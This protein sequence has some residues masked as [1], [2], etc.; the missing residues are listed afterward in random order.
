MFTDFSFSS[1]LTLIIIFGA[2][3]LLHIFFLNQHRAMSLLFAIYAS[4]LV[5]LF[6]P[7]NNW[8]TDMSLEKIVWFK[9]IGFLVLTLL[10]MFI[11][12]RS[13]VFDQRYQ[14][15]FVKFIKSVILGIVNAGLILSLLITLLPFKLLNK[16]SDFALKLLNTDVMR[17]IWL[18]LPLIIIL[19][20]VRMKFHRGPGRP[21][22]M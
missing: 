15:I 6:F 3:I 9:T 20:S 14:N 2:S 8:L 19:F 13:S 21:V 11:F 16:F 22:V 5:I 7:Y 18:V 4:Y 1:E 12:C 10:L 17:F